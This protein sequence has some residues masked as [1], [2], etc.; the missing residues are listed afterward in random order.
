MYF[1]IL[2]NGNNS[3][4][5]NIGI[6]SPEISMKELANKM[7][8]IAKEQFAYNG[9]LVFKNNDDVNYLTDNPNRRCPSILKARKEVG[10]NPKI[11]KGDSFFI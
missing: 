6:E 8:S 1:K 10:F 2:I 3:E 7:I 11:S 4:A 9:K 5:Y